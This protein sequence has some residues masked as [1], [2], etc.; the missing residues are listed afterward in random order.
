MTVLE[1]AR[2]FVSSLRSIHGDL[3]EHRIRLPGAERDR[4]IV[5][6]VDII[7][8]EEKKSEELDVLRAKKKIRK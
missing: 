7:D 2:N 5:G 1:E 6:L 3:F 4:L 8:Q